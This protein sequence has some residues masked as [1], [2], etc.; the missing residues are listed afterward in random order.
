MTPESH[1][2]KAGGTPITDEPVEGLADDKSDRLLGT[3]KAE[4]AV[5]RGGPL[6][7]WIRVTPEH[8]TTKPQ[9]R[10]WSIWA[11]STP[12]RFRPSRNHRRP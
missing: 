1:G 2:T 12:G 9:L 8:L 11:P 6:P 3:T 10:K 5:V 4:L 7:G